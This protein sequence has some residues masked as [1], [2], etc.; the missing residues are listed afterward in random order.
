MRWCTSEWG[1]YVT[2][3]TKAEMKK[4]VTEIPDGSFAKNWVEKYRGG[5]KEHTTYRAAELRAPTGDHPQAAPQADELLRSSLPNFVKSW[6]TAFARA[7]RGPS[8]PVTSQERADPGLW[9]RC[10]SSSRDFQ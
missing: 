3:A 9:N 8:A 10:D 6:S 5:L 1:D 4:G 2:D 7:M